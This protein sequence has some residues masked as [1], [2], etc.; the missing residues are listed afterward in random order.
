MLHCKN[1]YKWIII[2][3]CFFH[4]LFIFGCTGF[5]LREQRLIKRIPEEYR[6]HTSGFILSP[7]KSDIDRAIVLGKNSA[8]D[9]SLTY[10]YIIKGP[11]SI[12]SGDVYVRIASPLYL[13]SD[14]A[15]KNVKLFSCVMVSVSNLCLS[16]K[17][18]TDLIPL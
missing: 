18:S 13:I 17:A 16:L 6:N 3:F 15:R 9:D 4:F 7:T 2:I 12:W 5:G 1:K 10:A 8:N 14:Y 11:Y